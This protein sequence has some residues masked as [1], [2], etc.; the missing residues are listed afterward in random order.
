M[1]WNEGNTRDCTVDCQVHDR[2]TRT[3]GIQSNLRT[4]AMHG[5]EPF[6]LCREFDLISEFFGLDKVHCGG[7][8]E[9]LWQ[10]QETQFLCVALTPQN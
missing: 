4:T 8:N 5:D 7:L 6:G 2:N 9:R 3:E 10:N 1:H